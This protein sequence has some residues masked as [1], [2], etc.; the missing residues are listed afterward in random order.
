MRRF[1]EEATVLI[2]AF[3]CGW[4]IGAFACHVVNPDA[5]TSCQKPECRDYSRVCPPGWAVAE[6]R[7]WHRCCRGY[8]SGPPPSCCEWSR[9]SRSY[10]E[11]GCRAFRC[12]TGSPPN[13][14][15]EWHCERRYATPY[16]DRTNTYIC[17]P[18][19][20]YQN[21][22]EKYGYCSRL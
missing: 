8:L 16:G 18:L 11:P 22:G 20:S 1:K 10:V 13:Q 2:F 17:E 9:I 21:C 12:V 15:S 5:S 4:Q 6:I 14:R 3:L 7:N 19:G